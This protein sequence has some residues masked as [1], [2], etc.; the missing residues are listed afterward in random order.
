MRRSALVLA[1]ALLLLA[2]LAPVLTPFDPDR[3]ALLARLRPP[4]GFG[5]DWLHPLGTDPLGRD[6]AARC[7]YGLRT[8]LA[9]AVLGSLI[10]TLAGVAVGLAAGIRGGRLDALL[11]LLV[12]VQLALPYL[13]LVLMALAVFGIGLMLLIPLVS[14]AGW[15]HT[16]RLVRGQVLSLREQGFVEAAIAI[17]AAPLRITWRHVLPQLLPL[18]AVQVSLGVPHVMLLESSLSFLGI[19]VQ[20]PTASLG[21]MIGEGQAQMLGAWWIVAEPTLLMLVVALVVQMVGDGLRRR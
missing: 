16:A 6:M 7:L 20:P 1:G 10:G 11:M 19:G 18:L 17:G 21:R 9:I 14:L 15:E 4:L 3:T 12:D 8:S 13:L 5:G 2:A